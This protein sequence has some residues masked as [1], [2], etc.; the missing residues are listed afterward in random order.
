MTSDKWRIAERQKNLLDIRNQLS[1]ISILHNAA[2]TLLIENQYNHTP[3]LNQRI[4]LF[5][6]SCFKRE[7]EGDIF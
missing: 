7:S 2:I 5:C 3:F 4:K 1:T 6:Q